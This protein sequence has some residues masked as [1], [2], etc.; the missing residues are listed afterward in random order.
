MPRLRASAN[1][2]IPPHSPSAPSY[3]SPGLTAPNERALGCTHEHDHT[4]RISYAAKT[5]CLHN[6]RNKY[7]TTPSPHLLVHIQYT[8]HI[9]VLLFLL[10]QRLHPLAP[11]TGPSLSG[12][13][14]IVLAVTQDC[15]VVRSV[16]ERFT[17]SSGV[18]SSR[19]PGLTASI[20]VSFLARLSALTSGSESDTHTSS[21]NPYSSLTSS[22]SSLLQRSSL[23]PSSSA[24]YF[25]SST[26][27]NLFRAFFEAASVKGHF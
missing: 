16:R 24:G 22:R 7:I 3:T 13:L 9:I 8:L 12:R 6:P 15:R 17:R 25:F 5:S 2:L 1:D 27:S 23:N 20:A 21:M 26:P 18:P 14:I 4:G 11:T 10:I 19:R